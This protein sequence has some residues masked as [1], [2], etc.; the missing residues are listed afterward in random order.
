MATMFDRLHRFPRTE[1]ELVIGTVLSPQVLVTDFPGGT[2]PSIDEHLQVVDRLPVGAMQV[3]V[4]RMGGLFVRPPAELLETGPDD[5]APDIREIRAKVAFEADAADV[6]N[7]VQCELALGGH[8]YSLPTVP[9]AVESG[10]LIESHIAIRSAG[11]G[12]ERTL[13]PFSLLIQTARHT[14]MMAASLS[15]ATLQAI[16][17]VSRASLLARASRT[18]P[19]F[20]LAAYSSFHRHEHPEALLMGW[21]VTEQLIDELWRRYV[22]ALR[23]R[24]RRERLMDS[25]SYSAA[26]RIEVLEVAAVFDR[27]LA[28]RLHSARKL[29]NALAHRA[30]VT[31][32][33]AEI[34]IRT[35][36]AMLERWLGVTLPPVVAVGVGVGW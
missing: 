35:M 33:D 34:V 16:A 24:E 28:S 8:L 11:A 25:T 20:V 5:A 23:P 18:L 29:R 14:S 32:E 30:T 4:T 1:G 17:P 3:L 36:H 19:R 22:S 27:D 9:Y 10:W 13:G 2:F 21:I 26:V 6:F 15:P 7:L 31:G 12:A